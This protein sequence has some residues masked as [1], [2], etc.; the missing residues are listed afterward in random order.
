M[1]Q[2]SKDA[3]P[4]WVQTNMFFTFCKYEAEGQGMYVQGFHVI[5]MREANQVQ[6]LL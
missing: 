3:F 4:I 6:A 1:D 5:F 2:I